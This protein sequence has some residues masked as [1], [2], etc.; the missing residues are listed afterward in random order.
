MVM[1]ERFILFVVVGSLF[2]LLL[3]LSVFMFSRTKMIH[4]T[5]SNGLGRTVDHIGLSKLFSLNTLVGVLLVLI[6]ILVIVLSIL[7][8]KHYQSADGSKMVGVDVGMALITLCLGMSAIIPYFVG[9]SVAKNE[10]T[11][12]VNDRFDDEF[13]AINV[14]YKNTI[15]YLKRNMAHSAR[16]SGV[17][18][19]ETANDCK[20]HIWSVGWSC[21][22]LYEYMSINYSKFNNDCADNIIECSCRW[23][24]LKLKGTQCS[25]C[26]YHKTE[27]SRTYCE[28]SERTFYDLM[29]V[30]LHYRIN[31]GYIRKLDE[32]GEELKKLLANL[33]L[34]GFNKTNVDIRNDSSDIF[35]RYQ[36]TS[37]N[38]T[39]FLTGSCGEKEVKQVFDYWLL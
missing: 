5:K 28:I 35:R 9:A 38:Y 6:I 11:K 31:G 3:C 7:M 29:D 36:V 8:I 23:L 22:A 2:L 16:M 33:C 26:K 27:M 32:N 37:K 15:D 12:V 34:Y 10:L 30:L 14:Q 39:K 17:A 1:S 21:K 13:K 25:R 4:K 20:G 18:L 24:N 19:M